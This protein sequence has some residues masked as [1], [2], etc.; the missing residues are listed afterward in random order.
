MY[1]YEVDNTTRKYIKIKNVE[2]K[3]GN[4]CNYL[5]P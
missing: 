2:V 5:F 3:N 4:N 1:I